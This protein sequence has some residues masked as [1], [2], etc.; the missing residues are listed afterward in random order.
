MIPLLVGFQY[1]I[2]VSL[3][4]N[5]AYSK[6]LDHDNTQN[7]LA[8]N[9]NFR[10]F[11][12]PTQTLYVWMVVGKIRTNVSGKRTANVFIGKESETCLQNLVNLQTADFS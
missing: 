12:S 2:L 10:P 4:G 9:V 1:V 8:R 11:N 6:N 3:M 5:F 7:C